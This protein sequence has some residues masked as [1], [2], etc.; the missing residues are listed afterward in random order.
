MQTVVVMSKMLNTLQNTLTLTKVKLFPKPVVGVVSE[1]IT[2]QQ[3]GRVMLQGTYWPAQYDNPDCEITLVP[4][5]QVYVVGIKDIT[6]IVVPK[7][8]KNS[9][10]KVTG[11][12][13]K[14]RSKY[15][16]PFYPK[17]SRPA[18][19]T[20]IPCYEFTPRD[21]ETIQPV[22]KTRFPKVVPP[23]DLTDI[24][25]YEFTPIDLEAQLELTKGTACSTQTY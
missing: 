9:L 8:S 18:D 17:V 23:A 14:L 2:P 7:S 11:Y 20:E 25:C 13:E 6:L 3:P 1:P 5:Q 16:S 22:N 19:I 15:R 12:E 10:P 24:P 4:G 21:I